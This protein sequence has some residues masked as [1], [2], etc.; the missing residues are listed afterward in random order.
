MTF[1]NPKWTEVGYK[2]AK[3]EVEPYEHRNFGDVDFSMSLQGNF[4]VARR[5][6]CNIKVEI[7]VQ[8]GSRIPVTDLSLVEV[9][10]WSE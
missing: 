1:F 6:S 10:D 7:M 5:F 8:L 2:G 9:E 3:K 4:E